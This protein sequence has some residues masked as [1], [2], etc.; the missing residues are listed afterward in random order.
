MGS[1][2]IQG[3]L[4]E[5]GIH[6]GMSS[7]QFGNLFIRCAEEQQNLKEALR[8][9]VLPFWSLKERSTAI[10]SWKDKLDAF[11]NLTIVASP[12]IANSLRQLKSNHHI[13]YISS[14]N[15][16]ILDWNDTLLV[17]L[18]SDIWMDVWLAHHLEMPEFSDVSIAYCVEDE[19]SIPKEVTVAG[20]V[21]SVAEI[22]ILDERFA[23]FTNFALALQDDWQA[24]LSGIELGLSRITESSIWDNASALL[25]VLVR[26]LDFSP[27]V[28]TVFVSDSKMLSEGQFL[29]ALTCRMESRMSSE[30]IAKSSMVL[31][32]AVQIGEDGVFNILA[33]N[34]KQLV[35]LLWPESDGL[36]SPLQRAQQQQYQIVRQWLINEQVPHAIWDVPNTWTTRSRMAFRVQWVHRSLLT[37]AMQGDDPT[38]YESAD[39]WRETSTNLWNRLGSS[40][41]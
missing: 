20:R 21:E 36:D 16:E 15:T 5:Y 38:L 7:Q 4:R 3:A 12:L 17:I 14:V 31:S 22:G 10:Q 30:Q 26:G 24:A 41:N 35:V 1:L 9:S 28:E 13:K 23:L 40:L 33:A 27:Y 6:T 18:A 32:N 19:A 39:H 34:P 29:S 37:V 25:A 8:T 11:S 2:N